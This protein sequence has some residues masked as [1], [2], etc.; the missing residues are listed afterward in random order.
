MSNQSDTLVEVIQADR[1]AADLWK[2]E[3]EHCRGSHTAL[4]QAF[5][6]HRLSTRPADTD[7]VEALKAVRERTVAD[8]W[9]SIA[10]NDIREIVRAALAPQPTAARGAEEIECPGCGTTI[11]PPMDTMCACPPFEATAKAP[12][13]VD[14]VAVARAMYD[15]WPHTVIS[16]A[17]AEVTG[18]PI[19]EV[20]TWEVSL[21]CGANFG[22]LYRYADAVLPLIRQ[23]QAEAAEWMRERAAKVAEEEAAGHEGRTDPHDRHLV[24]KCTSTKLAAAIRALPA[25]ED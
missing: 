7:L 19:G 14:R 13:N 17:L 12:A 23:A 22:R 25:V 3:W 24:A 4:V 15:V 18:L 16:P 2:R 1:D 8:Q 21:K 5:A 11:S 20:L 6:R 9:F 10:L